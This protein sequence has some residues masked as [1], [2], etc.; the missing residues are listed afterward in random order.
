MIAVTTP[1]GQIGSKVVKELLKAGEAVRVIVR[2]PAKLAAEVR[3]R[4]EVVQGSSDDEDALLG[5]LENVESL[6]LVV[7]PSFTT[8]NVREYYLQFASPAARAVVKRGVKRIV[9]VSA[10]GRGLPLDGGLV[11]DSFAKDEELER[12]GMDFRA[13]WCPGFMENMFRQIESLKHQGTFFGPSL[14]DVKLPLVATRD[15]ASTGTKLLLDRS[16]TGQG[17]IAVLGPEDLSNNDMAII[18]S[19]VLGKPIRY[20]QLPLETYKAQMVQFG[21]SEHFAQRLA[22]MLVAKDKGLDCAEPRT[23]ENT[24]PTTFRQWCE[25]EL[26]PAILRQE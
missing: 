6:F 17:G 4:I 12:T 19:D 5:A 21:A 10:L 16:W 15:I 23:I 8:K 25:D 11:S 22:D 3:E 7:P 1:T 24:T 18:L 14:P 20:V 13:L 26:K 2:N 9:A